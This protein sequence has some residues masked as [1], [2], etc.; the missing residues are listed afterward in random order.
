[1]GLGRASRSGTNWEREEWEKTMDVKVQ[2]G[3]G[4]G[5]SQWRGGECHMS[6]KREATR[7]KQRKDQE[8]TVR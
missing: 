8:Q 6:G 2:S 3:R 5:P 7:E 1:M 4:R